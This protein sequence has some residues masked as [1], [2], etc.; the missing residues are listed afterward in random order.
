MAR[1]WL[2]V[3]GVTA[4]LLVLASPVLSM[5]TGTEALAQFPKD[6]DVRVGSELAS[7]ELGGGTDP[8]Q[9]IASFERAARRRRPAPRSRAFDREA[10][11]R[12]GVSATAPPVYAATAP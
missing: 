3:G 4:V 8:I 9:I 6:S 7:E 11:R 2:A 12:P 10:A 1:P 5:K